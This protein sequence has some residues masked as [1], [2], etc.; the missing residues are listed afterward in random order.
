MKQTE[1]TTLASAGPGRLTAIS[2]GVLGLG[3]IVLVGL[4]VVDVG[5]LRSSASGPVAVIDATR[6]A[7][8]A[9]YPAVPGL[10]LVE[11]I[12][13]D[14]QEAAPAQTRPD[15]IPFV[16]CDMPGWTAR[17]PVAP[18]RHVNLGFE[19]DPRA[20][21]TVAAYEDRGGLEANVNRWL[22]QVGA[23]PLSAEEVAALPRVQMLGRGEATL[24]EAY[25][26]FQGMRGGRIEEGGVLGAIVS[27]E[28]F[29]LFAKFTGPEVVLRAEKDRFI[30]FLGSLRPGQAASGGATSAPSTG[31]GQSSLTWATPD[32][33][34]DEAP[35]SRFRERTF[36][37]GGIEISLSL[38]RGAVKP[39]VNRWAAELQMQALDDAAVAALPTLPSMG[40]DAV[41]FEGVGSYKGMRDTAA[42]ADQRMLAAIVQIPDAGG[43]IATLKAVG[44]SVEVDEA[45]ADFAALLSSLGVR[46][47]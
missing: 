32:G 15:V 26:P 18:F 12:G 35:T 37:K 22:G 19:A 3:V 10:S 36:R 25:G 45:R 41:I 9:A 5:W 8:T 42:R 34:T 43:T 17:Q 1:G 30:E 21:L 24:V 29:T 28:R 6:V 44:P 2:L 16:F 14:E 13:A 40:T 46:G 4:G 23:A 39:N 27:N 20:E 31:D 11:R 7:S 33:W 38:A 47:R